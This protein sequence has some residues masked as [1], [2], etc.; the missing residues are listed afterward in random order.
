[1]VKIASCQINKR[2]FDIFYND[3]QENPR[4]GEL[5]PCTKH[6]RDLVLS[7]FKEDIMVDL[8]KIGDAVKK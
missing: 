6:D 8:G 7:Y 2:F 4:E 5:Y 1:M 3:K